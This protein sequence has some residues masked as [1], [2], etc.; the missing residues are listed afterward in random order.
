MDD[1]TVLIEDEKERM[2]NKI[3]ETQILIE[4]SISEWEARVKE[5]DQINQRKND[6]ISQ[7][8][9]LHGEMDVFKDSYPEELRTFYLDEKYKNEILSIQKEK[10]K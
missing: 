5:I 8:A 3:D 7:K 4:R 9:K 2:E 6:L 1:A 10:S